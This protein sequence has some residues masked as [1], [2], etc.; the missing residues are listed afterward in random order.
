M[1]PLNALVSQ[2]SLINTK[3]DQLSLADASS[4]LEFPPFQSRQSS[5]NPNIHSKH[6]EEGMVQ[7]RASCYRRTCRP[8]CSC[9]CH[10]RRSVR[11]PGVMK[12]FIGS[13]FMGY[14]GVPGITQPCNETQCKRRSSTRFILS[15]QFPEWFWTRALFASFVKST[16]F[17][18]EMLLRVQ[19]TI[20]WASE[21]YNFCVDGNV[22]G[23]QRLFEEGSAS[24]FDVDPRGT[25]LLH[26]KLSLSLKLYLC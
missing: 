12:S 25:S 4:A 20:P 1:A 7:I 3:L 9:R 23:L 18:P 15:Y 11:T 6:E 2:T 21:T 22:K 19:T 17:G 13:L 14:S 10:V 16:M 26:V 8:W 5:N 24:P